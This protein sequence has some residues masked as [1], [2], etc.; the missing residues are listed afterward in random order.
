M[1]TFDAQN[2]YYSDEPKLSF[3]DPFFFKH[4]GKKYIIFCAKDKNKPAG[5]QGCVGIVEETG[6]NE[7]KWLPPLYS[8]GKYFDGLECPTLYHIKNKWYL[9]YGLDT[10]NAPSHYMAYAISENAFGPFVAPKNNHL[11][12]EGH[13][14]GRMV[15]FKNRLLYYSWFRDFPKGI[16]RER[17]AKP[18]EVQTTNNGKIK[19][20]KIY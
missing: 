3:R 12:L 8:P 14:I 16:T 10:K 7:F 17:L 20:S 1:L 5:K 2:P 4:D 18:R 13:Y 6:S 9:L 11:S 15:E 19:L